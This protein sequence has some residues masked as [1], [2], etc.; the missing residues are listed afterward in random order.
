MMNRYIKIILVI[1]FLYLIYY[2]FNVQENFGYMDILREGTRITGIESY[3][4]NN[5]PIINLGSGIKVNTLGMIY[6]PG[7]KYNNFDITFLR[8]NPIDKP[9]QR[10]NTDLL[11]NILTINDMFYGAKSSNNT[12]LFHKFLQIENNSKTIN[13][14]YNPN[15]ELLKIKDF[16]TEEKLLNWSSYDSV[17]RLTKKN[18][19]KIEFIK[20]LMDINLKDEDTF[21]ISDLRNNYLSLRNNNLEFL[22]RDRLLSNVIWK[23]ELISAQ[24]INLELNHSEQKISFRL[25]SQDNKY[26]V[27]NNNYELSC[28]NNNSNNKGVIWNMV[29]NQKGKKTLVSENIKQNN[30]FIYLDIDFEENILITNNEIKNGLN[31]ER[32]SLIDTEIPFIDNEIYKFQIPEINNL[33]RRVY[34]D[35]DSNGNLISLDN[36]EVYL[37]RVDLEN[38][39]AGNQNINP[40]FEINENI[41]FTNQEVDNIGEKLTPHDFNKP[42]NINR[43]QKDNQI[44]NVTSNVRVNES[45]YAAGYPCNSGLNDWKV[46]IVENF[47]INGGTARLLVRLKSIR[48]DYLYRTPVTTGLFFIESNSDGSKPIN[49][50]LKIGPVKRYEKLSTDLGGLHNSKYP[51]WL[52]MKELTE[53]GLHCFQ[54]ST[55]PLSPI[56]QRIGVTRNKN[57][58]G[59]IWLLY[60]IRDPNNMGDNDKIRWGFE[61]HSNNIFQRNL[62]VSQINLENNNKS[63]NY[64]DLCNLQGTTY[65]LLRDLKNNSQLNHLYKGVGG[66]VST[67]DQKLNYNKGFIIH[68][69]NKRYQINANGIYRS[70]YPGF[71]KF[72]E[73]NSR[74]QLHMDNYKIPEKTENCQDIDDKCSTY[75]CFLTNDINYLQNDCKRTCFWWRTSEANKGN[76]EF[77]NNMQEELNNSDCIINN[78]EYNNEI[79]IKSLFPENMQKKN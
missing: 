23:V 13:Q 36:Q 26:L 12:L 11:P 57:Q 5:I 33:N 74:Y 68:N 10:P 29:K 75:N 27:I 25:K 70:L 64:I 24:N 60:Q 51:Y 73:G 63:I 38:I 54:Q 65:T 67:R 42:P 21:L 14:Y 78:K 35:T 16:W 44:Y 50:S 37:T 77:D 61:S 46:E 41:T 47:K 28:T 9:R 62:T 6:H 55:F 40:A 69:Q 48:G 59:T 31:F 15:Y 34:Y 43:I 30:N 79:N 66:Q 7:Q 18:S 72:E 22:K 20:P 45:I 32:C 56:N 53:H 4:Q 58:D 19:N 39:G 71:L 8:N 3:L 49:N 2:F 76:I 52:S 17:R 1:I